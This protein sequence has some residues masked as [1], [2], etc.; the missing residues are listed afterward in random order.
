MYRTRILNEQ[1]VEEF[2]DKYNTNYTSIMIKQENKKYY[3]IV[4]CD[5][6][7]KMCEK[8]VIELF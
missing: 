6:K 4:E 7:I 1:E 2:N 8:E 3:A 5:V